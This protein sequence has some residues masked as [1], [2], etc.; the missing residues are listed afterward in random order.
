[1]DHRRKNANAVVTNAEVGVAHLLI[2]KRRI[3]YSSSRQQ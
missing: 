1:M 3:G 2:E